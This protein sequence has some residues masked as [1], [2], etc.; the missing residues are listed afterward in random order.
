MSSE[1]LIAL[2]SFAGTCLGSIT[3]VLTA[4]KL[5]NFRISELEKKVDR[6]NQ[7]LDRVAVNE[8]DM[9]ALRQV[10]KEYKEKE[11]QDKV[12]LKED[13]SGIHDNIG[14]IKSDVTHINEKLIKVEGRVYN[15]ETLV[16][17]FHQT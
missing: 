3:A 13:I 12:E 5:V 16:K 9:E 11:E 8:A 7:V 6:H 2:L 14:E 17:T 1:I 4:N 15:V 10:V